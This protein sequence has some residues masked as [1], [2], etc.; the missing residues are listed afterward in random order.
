M[1]I[2]LPIE[3]IRELTHFGDTQRFSVSIGNA[4]NEPGEVKLIGPAK[5]GELERGGNYV[6]FGEWKNHPKHGRQFKFLSF[7]KATPH[8]R[9]GV[10][11][12]LKDIH[13]IGPKRA[14][15]IWEAFDADCIELIKRDPA[16]VAA[17][18]KGLTLEMLTD[19]AKALAEME[20]V[21]QVRL[22]LYDLLDGRG[23]PK[24]LP[25]KCIDEWGNAAPKLIRENPFRLCIFPRVGFARCDQLYLDIGGEPGNPERQVHLLK[26][27]VD[28]D[29]SGSTWLSAKAIESK[30]MGKMTAANLDFR[31]ALIEAENRQYID[32]GYLHPVGEVVASWRDSRAERVIAERVEVLLAGEATWPETENITDITDHQRAAL[33]LAMKKPVGIL[34]GPPGCGKTH[35]LAR[36]VRHIQVCGETN[37]VVCAATGKA[38]RRIT[39][40]MQTYGIT[41]PAITIHRLL[42]VNKRDN[43]EGF[44]FSFCA[45]NPLPHRWIFVDEP[46]MVDGR[47]MAALLAAVSYTSHI[48]FAGDVNQLP[49]VGR[50][51]PMRDLI[52]AGVPTGELTEIHRNGGRIVTACKE[53]IARQRFTPSLAL[54]IRANPPEN[55]V[56]FGE[57]TAARQIARCEH[58]IKQAAEAGGKDAKWDIQL[59]CAVNSKSKLSRKALNTH[60]QDVLNPDGVRVEGNPFRVGDKVVNRENSWPRLVDPQTARVIFSSRGTTD[61]AA[62]GMWLA[63]AASYEAGWDDLEKNQYGECWVANGDMGEVL[64]VEANV[65]VVKFDSPLRIV[66][67][68]RGSGEDATGKL[69]MGYVLSSHLAQGSQWPYVIVFLDDYAGARMVTSRNWLYTAIS[70]SEIACVL[71]GKREVAFEMCKRDALAVRRTGLVERIERE[72]RSAAVLAGVGSGETSDGTF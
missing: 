11:R 65:T 27:L 35:A 18:I 36:L 39:E 33:S 3:L 54:N 24:S 41:K 57:G 7:A 45:G 9:R 12:F 4:P 66:R 63:L 42:H 31:A 56:V 25:D 30:F 26:W 61:A 44:E 46:S 19:A 58:F 51:A 28:S 68:P 49:P 52:A 67:I 70:R 43:E 47:L 22:E 71:I 14:A 48:L 21:Q 50:G 17:K 32:I 72:R 8:S 20:H 69:E 23:F 1:P 29:N 64:L 16:A 34:T 60:F 6:F 38:A 5:H 53:I 10:I 37:Y 62:A 55:L 15:A 59:L 2:E 13:G 40:V